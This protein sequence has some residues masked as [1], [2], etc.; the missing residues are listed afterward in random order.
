MR[1]YL[2]Y[3]QESYANYSPYSQLNQKD[4]LGNYLANCLQF[5]DKKTKSSEV[6]LQNCLQ[7]TT[8]NLKTYKIGNFIYQWSGKSDH[9]FYYDDNSYL[10]TIYH[11]GG[12]KLESF[13]ILQNFDVDKEFK[14]ALNWYD[15]IKQEF[16]IKEKEFYDSAFFKFF[17]LKISTCCKTLEF[18]GSFRDIKIYFKISWI[19]LLTF[20]DSKCE[21]FLKEFSTI[22]KYVK[23]DLTLRIIYENN[24]PKI[25]MLY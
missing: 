22:C 15:S 19:E 23:T 12:L 1:S 4:I 21:E 16:K 24:S 7:S 8:K 6:F 13:L 18:E 5:Y 3:F 10:A 11:Y 20:S 14:E 2:E 25:Y 17:H 9:S